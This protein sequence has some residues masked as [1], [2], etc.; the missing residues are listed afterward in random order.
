MSWQL[1]FVGKDVQ[2]CLGV[3]AGIQM[4]AV[5]LTSSAFSSSE[6]VRLPLWARPMPYGEL[7]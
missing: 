6:L 4:P 7:T 3:G 1:K 5:L 2:Q